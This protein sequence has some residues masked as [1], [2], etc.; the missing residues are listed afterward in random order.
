MTSTDKTICFFIA[1]VFLAFETVVNDTGDHVESLDQIAALGSQLETV[2][3]AAGAPG[4]V[5]QDDAAATA[6]IAAALELL[7][8]ALLP[9]APPHTLNPLAQIWSDKQ[10]EQIAK[11]I[12]NLCKMHGFTVDEFFTKYGPYLQLMAALGMPL[13][14]TIKILKMPPPQA[15]D[16]QQQQAQS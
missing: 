7:R 10:L 8:A 12:V 5:V 6:E 1:C 16:G 11:A 15:P 14:A 3:P 4:A 2:E 9:F 13:L